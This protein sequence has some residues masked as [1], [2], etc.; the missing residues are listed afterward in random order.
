MCGCFNDF[1]LGL[2]LPRQYEAISFPREIWPLYVYASYFFSTVKKGGLNLHMCKKNIK[3]YVYFCKKLRT[4]ML[5]RKN[6]GTN[7]DVLSYPARCF[8]FL[9]SMPSLDT[10]LLNTKIPITMLTC[11]KEG[12]RNIKFSINQLQQDYFNVK[13]IVS[14]LDLLYK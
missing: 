12:N 5:R 4:R 13:D 7:K 2:I 9:S 3:A 6:R 1:H 11:Q 14:Q 8:S 10:S